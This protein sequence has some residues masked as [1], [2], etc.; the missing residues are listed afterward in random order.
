M[1]MHQLRYFVAV[2]EELNVTRAAARIHVSQQAVSK[3]VA[4]LERELDVT[5]FDR[6]ARG[7]SLTAA[8]HVFLRD[9]VGLLRQ[10][11]RARRTVRAD[12]RLRGPEL[13]VVDFCHGTRDDL[14]DAYRVE[15]PDRTL[16]VHRALT[17]EEFVA[18]LLSGD[19]DAMLL[20]GRLDADADVTVDLVHQEPRAAL[21]PAASEYA[22]APSLTAEDLLDACFGPRHPLEPRHWEGDWNLVPERG[23][24]PR[25]TR[26]DLPDRCVD[27]IASI[28][29]TGCVVTHSATMVEEWARWSRGTMV[30]I[31]MPAARP[32]ETTLATTAR[33]TAVTELRE[34]LAGRHAV[35]A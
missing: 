20:D 32:V 31:P 18:P 34:L 17:M 5:L 24:Q 1:E 27:Q 15:F 21:V 26:Y 10:A 29:A 16:V 12:G 8:G 6:R 11:D 14:L 35:P 22:A 23:E 28:A 2:A 9:A 30:P 25:R 13:R 3:A 7:C 33:S 19:V 4:A